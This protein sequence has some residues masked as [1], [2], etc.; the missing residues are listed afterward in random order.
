MCPCVL[1]ADGV[2]EGQLSGTEGGG[3]LGDPGDGS[4]AGTLPGPA[5]STAGT[6]R[7]DGRAEAMEGAVDIEMMQRMLLI[8]NEEA[9]FDSAAKEGEDKIREFDDQVQTLSGPV[10]CLAGCACSIPAP[11]EPSL[12]LVPPLSSPRSTTRRSYCKR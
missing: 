7:S 9:A 3:A 4:D 5:A 8:Q 11:H 1:A 2:D 10:C 12:C 6:G